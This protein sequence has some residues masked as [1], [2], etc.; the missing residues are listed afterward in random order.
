MW[1]FYPERVI[2]ENMKKEE[3]LRL[4]FIQKE[5]Q[6]TYQNLYLVPEIP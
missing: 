5:N 3:N 2:E 1:P 4:L 6:N